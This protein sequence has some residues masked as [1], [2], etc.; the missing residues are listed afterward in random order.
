MSSFIGH[1]LVGFITGFTSKEPEKSSSW[2]KYWIIWLIIVA[3]APDLDYFISFLN[4]SNHNGIRITHSIFGVLILPILTIVVLLIINKSRK[5]LKSLSFQVLIAG[6]SHIILDI[7]VGVYNNPYFW[8]FSSKVYRLPFG[9]LPS[10]GTLDISNYYLYRNLLIE[11]G[12][13]LPILICIYLIRSTKLKRNY[14][15]IFTIC[16]SLI[17]IGFMYWAFGL[18]R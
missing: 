13:L 17:S 14:K 4:S 7:L 11:M 6:V 3:M 8:P 18:S 1:G 12:V 9:I 15:I 2:R 10:A 5:W 16:L